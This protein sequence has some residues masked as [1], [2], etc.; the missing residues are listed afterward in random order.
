MEEIFIV[1]FSTIPGVWEIV[2]DSY[3][4]NELDAIN[5]A[6]AMMER[7]KKRVLA[8]TKKLKLEKK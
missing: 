2:G 3:Y 1:E 5:V 6:N 7:T 8:R 4:I